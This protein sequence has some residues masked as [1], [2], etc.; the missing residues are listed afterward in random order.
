[1]NSVRRV[2]TVRDLIHHTGG[3]QTRV[4]GQTICVHIVSDKILTQRARVY[5][6]CF[7]HCMQ[8]EGGRGV[9]GRLAL[10]ED[11]EVIQLAN[12]HI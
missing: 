8:I 5:K 10:S 3:V 12:L 6:R 4:G 7:I 2:N 1:M 9:G 11:P